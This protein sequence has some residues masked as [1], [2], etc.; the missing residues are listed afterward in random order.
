M[1]KILA[2]LTFTILFGNVFLTFSQ[3]LEWIRT[4]NM[5]PVETNDVC[6]DDNDRQYSISY[7]NNQTNFSFNGNLVSAPGTYVHGAIIKSNPAGS[8]EWIKFFAPLTSNA[9]CIPNR[10][11]YSDGFVYVAGI[12]NGSI[13]MD[14]GS[15]VNFLN[16]TTSPFV[17]K[18]DT[19]GN[20]IWAKSFGSVNAKVNDL[21][22]DNL[23]NVFITGSFNT[24]FNFNNIPYSSN[25]DDDVYFLKFNNQGQEQWCRTLGSNSFLLESGKSIAIDSNGDVLIAGYFAETID[26]DTGPGN[27]TLSSSGGQDGFVTKYSQNGNH[28]NTIKIGGINSDRINS[29][30]VNNSS[31]FI[32]GQIYGTVDLDPGSS[33]F[34]VTTPVGSTPGFILRLDNQF[35]LV[36]SRVIST[37]SS[38]M[39]LEVQ[40]TSSNVY[41]SGI[42]TGT[43][44]LDSDPVNSFSYTA[45]GAFSNSYILKLDINGN[46]IWGAGFLN[47]DNS[48]MIGNYGYENYPNG[49][50]ISNNAVYIGGGYKGSVDFN[51]N[52]NNSQITPSTTTPTGIGVMSGYLVKLSN[53]QSNGSSTSI[54]QCQSYTWPENNTTYSN[55]GLYTQ[56]LTNINGCD[57]IVSLNLTILP[58][59]INSVSITQCDSYTSPLGNNYNTSGTYNET[60]SNV[61]GCDSVVT[62]NLTITNLQNT[63]SLTNCGTYISPLGNSYASS[64]TYQEI[65]STQ[66]GC[67]STVNIL[68]TINN[69]VS[70]N[71][72][73]TTCSSFISPTGNNYTES[74]EYFDTLTTN[75]GCDSIIVIQLTILNPTTNIISPIVCNSY[76]SPSGNV[77]NQTGTYIDTI[78]NNNGCDSIIT[79]NLQ[80]VGT[81]NVDAGPDINI[82]AEESIVLSANGAINY[83]WNNGIQNGVA[84]S[85]SSTSYFTVTGTDGNGCSGKDSVL[86]TVNN[87]PT[88]S[89]NYILPDCE[90]GITGSINTQVN[91]F[92]PISY[93]WSTGSTNQNLQDVSAGTYN[94]IVIDGNGCS[95]NQNFNLPDGE[96]DCLIIPT[97]FTPNGDNQNDTWQ[98]VGIENFTKNNVQVFNR[99]GQTVFESQGTIVNWDGKYK[100]E[101]LP[102][103]DYYFVVDLGNGQV[104][105][106]TVT[107]KY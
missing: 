10:I 73:I 22:V 30:D 82:C 98:I 20:F 9:S 3:N 38:S 7:G 61:N 47:T 26:F 72:S 92:N 104:F 31:I 2:F 96:G 32:A 74:G 23:G 36:W 11:F 54:T 84:F 40:S 80:V 28:I 59:Q 12:N 16:G 78:Q 39:G 75:L 24:S 101:I 57:S 86:V 62:I 103:A 91:G 69:D 51:P 87:P 65:Y 68:L 49:F 102:I 66:T 85:P 5:S 46:F 29:I 35:N 27:F 17:V 90:G 105:N 44:D 53:C 94:L 77:Y 43:T 60:Y 14:P 42:M 52:Q 76:T 79:I 48:F 107:L 34:N 8:H 67:D 89:F 1:K 18:L 45:N 70:I 81:L 64:G 97:G 83:S 58:T 15:A 55:S 41:L 6:A 100:D 63:I 50:A 95:E 71:Q 99:W 88:I 13:D 19:V 25:G 33:T 93:Q 56:T 106:G 21:K 4:V 37:T